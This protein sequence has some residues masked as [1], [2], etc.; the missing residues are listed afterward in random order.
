MIRLVFTTIFLFLCLGSPAIPSDKDKD[1][2]ADEATVEF[3]YPQKEKISERMLGWHLTR[4][5]G[6]EMGQPEYDKEVSHN[7]LPR[8][9]SRQDVR[10]CHSFLPLKH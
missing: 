6:E 9:T 1:D 7:H 8:L 2:L 10:H 5:K 4:G 3:S